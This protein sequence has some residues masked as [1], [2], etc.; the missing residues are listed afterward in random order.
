MDQLLGAMAIFI[1]YPLLAAAV[2]IVLLVLGRRTRR[3]TAVTAGVVWLLYAL[4]ETGMQKRWLCSGECN[5]RV[6]LL[7]LYPLLLLSLIAGI[8]SLVR[9]RSR[10]A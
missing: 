10:K 4:Y 3:G 6:D 1:A 8:V 7:L 2:G 9:R 5:I